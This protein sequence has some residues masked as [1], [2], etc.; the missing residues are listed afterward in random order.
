M[1]FFGRERVTENIIERL[2]RQRLVFIHGASGCGKSSLVRAGVLPRLERQHLSRGASWQTCAMR[3]S[4]GPL[5]NLAAEFARLEDRADDSTRIDE[6]VR[7]CN[8]RD[9]TFAS[10]AAAIEG[11]PGK[12]LCILVDQF[13]ELFRFEHEVS[14][15]EAELFIDLLV[16]T[17]E[18]AGEPDDDELGPPVPLPTVSE[19]DVDIRVIVTMRSEFLGDCA[20]FD[21]LAE[22]INRTQY[23]VPRMS[24][25]ALLR[26]IRR[27]AQIY[28]GDV[29][30]D[31]ADR[32]IAEVRG[33]EDELP[34]I[35]H[36]LMLLWAEEEAKATA[37]IKLDADLLEKRGSLAN[38]LSDHADTVM[39]NVGKDT[40][41][42]Q[43]V[44]TLFR[45]LIEQTTQKRA[46]RRPQTFRDL[47][48]VV[49]VE[50]PALRAIIDRFR[51]DGVSFLTPARTS[52]AEIEDETI[53]DIGHEA[54]IRCWRK[55]SDEKDGWLKR[56]TEDGIIWS[57]LLAEAKEFA[58]NPKQIL[59]GEKLKHRVR[60]LATKQE[61]WRNRYGG[62]SA[63]ISNFIKESKR[64]AN[65][66]RTRKI[67][68]ISFFSS[69]FLL[70]TPSI[71]VGSSVEIDPECAKQLTEP[72]NKNIYAHI[73]NYFSV[74]FVSLNILIWLILE[75]KWFS[76][77]F[78]AK[79]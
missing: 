52:V 31:L 7:L 40:P 71:I 16:G 12:R 59:S 70:M 56:E 44:E 65:R 35:Q 32:L 67:L 51:E 15:E 61:A 42:K 17:L 54:L 13:E 26:A 64:V 49:N 19:R 34:L 76:S 18:P 58:I 62:N 29:S 23:L 48:A 27:P 79:T 3:P 75:I 14:R 25:E 50:P 69:I 36:G 5:W 53:I 10:V 72:L 2:A 63:L 38:L 8:R 46:I 77:R 33:R 55:I 78:V 68:S 4:N 28:G 20:R 6:I 21:G 57:L 66:I 43:A 73:A 37:K 9:A 24:R 30:L 45:A 39:D 11:L 22:A 1:I 60:W 41:R 74:G 47:A